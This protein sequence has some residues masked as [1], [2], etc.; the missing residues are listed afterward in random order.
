MER[1]EL[2]DAL[3]TVAYDPRRVRCLDDLEPF[4]A[5]AG[6][7]EVFAD[8][9]IAVTSSDVRQTLAAAE[10]SPEFEGDVKYKLHRMPGTG[11]VYRVEWGWA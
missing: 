4:A 10:P 1:E 2:L 6:G 3:R 11:N 5:L 8:G 9:S 7:A